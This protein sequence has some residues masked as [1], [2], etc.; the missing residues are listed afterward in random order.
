M[1]YFCRRPAAAALATYH[2]EQLLLRCSRPGRLAAYVVCPGVLYG[3]G[4]DDSQ[5]HSVWRAAWEGQQPL[6]L[7]GE[8]RNRLPTL[9]VQDLAAFAEAVVLQQPAARYLL[10]CDDGPVSQAELLAAV[11]QLLGNKQTQCGSGCVWL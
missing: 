6:Q 9:H 7:H 8:G 4:E 1:V 11:G 3:A 2:L 5:L 10:A